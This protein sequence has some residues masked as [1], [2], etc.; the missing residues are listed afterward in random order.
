M[1]PARIPT[2]RSRGADRGPRSHRG[3]PHRGRGGGRDR[4]G[5]S[6]GRQPSR[7][8]PGDASSGQPP[9]GSFG[10]HL[11]EAALNTK[12][13]SVSGQEAKNDTTT[14]SGKETAAVDDTETEAP[15][16][17]FTD[18]PEKGF[19]DFKESDFVNTDENLGI[20]YDKAV[21][22]EDTLLLLRYNCPDNDCDV[23]CYGWPDLH[24]HVKS[25]HGKVM[26]DLCTRNKKVFTHEHELFSFGELRRHE[27]YGDDN[28]GAV[29]QSGFK[30]HPECGFC[31]QRFYGDDEL[32]HHCR[33]KH[34]RCHICDRRN[35]GARPEYYL[36]YQE[37]EKH[38][39]SAHFVC[40]DAECQANKT[41]VFDSEMDLKAHQLSEHPNGLS[42]DS[43]R[44]A[45]LVNLS[46]FD[47]RTPY[48]PER[49]RRGNG[50]GRDPNAESIPTSSAQPLSRAEL[51]F[52]R[53]MA[54]QS[55]QSLTPRTFGGQLTQ[56]TTTPPRPVTSRPPSRSAE[57]TQPPASD[58]FTD[59]A[60]VTLSSSPRSQVR[61]ARHT[62]VTNRASNLL[63]ND[64]TKLSRFRSLISSYRA[65]TTSAPDLLDG[66][67]SLFDCPSAE[68]GILIR[69]LADLFEDDSKRTDLL[70]AWHDWRSINEAY[71]SLPLPQGSS[72]ASGSSTHSNSTSGRRVLKLKS[73]TQQSAQSRTARQSSWGSV[74][75]P[76]P[77]LATNGTSSTSPYLR[78]EAFP[79]LPGASAPSISSTRN[80]LS[81]NNISW[82][83]APNNID[84]SRRTKTETT[85][86]TTAH[87]R[88]LPQLT[89]CAKTR[90]VD[91]WVQHARNGYSQFG[92]EYAG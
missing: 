78:A 43:R 47:V 68:L 7:D 72:G 57:S 83:A 90:R 27:K 77:A 49:Q 8:T 55:S 13:E 87:A 51:A 59:L 41:N 82:N 88:P 54:I 34:E 74:L 50:R 58:I 19:Q 85:P 40:L 45:R 11:T 14:E 31:R 16:V 84:N 37:L 22:R 42:K 69:E 56:S 5:G 33:E 1:E 65:S 48:H 38:F 36:N 81:S 53:Q 20:K 9:G 32:Y 62:A 26:C 24:R 46:G 67:F 39:A 70:N 15:Y 28:P 44:D 2:P 79:S 25:K 61:I 71:P 92:H 64:I 52:Q 21:I 17:I 30:G 73:S 60:N 4:A 10:A 6:H 18:S 3:P 12:G 89:H 29:D 91:Q 75:L 35:G 23:A 66:F 80:P 76:S 86:T 63:H